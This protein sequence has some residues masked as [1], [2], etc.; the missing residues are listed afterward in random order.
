VDAAVPVQ[1]QAALVEGILNN[2][3]DNA[4]RYGRAPEGEAS[5]VTVAIK[6]A[7]GGST[8]LSVSDNGPGMDPGQAGD[9]LERWAQG[10]S[11]QQLGQGAGLG[12]AIVAQ[13]ARL[14]GA[15]LEL[16]GAD[17]GVGQAVCVV[18]PAG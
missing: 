3:L 2:L 5:H 6:P 10:R 12:L 4:L 1:G 13:Y 7:E 15:R 17:G 11:G 9:L 16:R 14:M 18:F 8:V